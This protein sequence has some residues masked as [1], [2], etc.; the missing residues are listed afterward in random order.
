[1]EEQPLVKD[2][3][4]QITEDETRIV[5]KIEGNGLDGQLD[6]AVAAQILSIQHEIFRIT[7]IVMFGEEASSKRLPKDIQNRLFIQ[8]KVER[9]CSE[10]LG[11]LLGPITTIFTDW[12]N[13]MTPEQL[14]QITKTIAYLIAGGYVSVKLITSAKE[15]IARYLDNKHAQQ[16]SLQ[17]NQHAEA[18]AD[19]VLE[20]ASGAPDKIIEDAS[21]NFRTANK[22]T[23]GPRKLN[24]QQLDE[25]RGRAPK[26]RTKD[27]Q[28]TKSFL[29][30]KLNGQNRPTFYAELQE[31]P[32]GDTVKA[33]YSQPEDSLFEGAD[34]SDDYVVRAMSLAFAGNEPIDLS[35]VYSRNEAGEV[36]RVVILGTA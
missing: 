12:G 1:M 29:V 3:F 15:L 9:G 18:I 7:K 33:T 2:N 17:S 10:L 6:A 19:K 24:Q 32:E 13:K 34:E 8:F 14:V 27:T 28:E 20:A 22:M 26:K 25:F 23:Y 35:V 4:E 36:V 30:L 31:F 21:K 11:E 5:L 16:T